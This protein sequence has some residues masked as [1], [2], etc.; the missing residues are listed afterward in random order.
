[1]LDLGDK[2]N[3]VVGQHGFLVGYIFWCLI[4]RYSIFFFSSERN[5]V[6]SKED[7]C[8][9]WETKSFFSS[10][11][12]TLGT[13]NQMKK[14]Y[15]FYYVIM[16]TPAHSVKKNLVYSNLLKCDQEIFYFYCTF[17]R[18]VRYLIMYASVRWDYL[19]LSK[20]ILNTRSTLLYFVCRSI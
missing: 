10:I 14:K 15:Y 18:F 6:R 13:Q 20:G 4:Y 7:R 3:N 19:K 17:L 2:W 8:F 11:I 9:V 16:R 1:M 12:S 5:D